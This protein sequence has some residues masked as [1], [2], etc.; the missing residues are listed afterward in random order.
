MRRNSHFSFS[1]PLPLSP[2]S[3]LPLSFLVG[4]QRST[5]DDGVAV[6]TWA[7]GSGETNNNT[8]TNII[9]I[10]NTID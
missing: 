9:I 1:L 7:V 2:V 10:L 8:N 5:E 4:G 3:L 6:A